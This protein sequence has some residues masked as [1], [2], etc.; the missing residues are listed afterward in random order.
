MRLGGLNQF[1]PTSVSAP[2]KARLER[3]LR[4]LQTEMHEHNPYVGLYKHLADVQHDAA[5]LKLALTEKDLP[6]NSTRRYTA[7]NSQWSEITKNLLPG[8]TWRDRP[9]LVSRVFKLKRDSYL[10]DI[11]KEGIFGPF[12]FRLAQVGLASW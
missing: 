9:D 5:P 7:H 8:Q 3:I 2:E 12:A 6:Q 10:R 11:T 4:D 1:L